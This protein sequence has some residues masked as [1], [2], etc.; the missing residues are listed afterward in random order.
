M[1]AVASIPKPADA[2]LLAD[3]ATGLT[4]TDWA[5]QYDPNNPNLAANHYRLYRVAYA[6]G[7]SAIPNFFA[8]GSAPDIVGP[9]NPAWDSLARHSNG[10]NIAFADGHVKHLA[11]SAITVPLYGIK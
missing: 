1:A 4:G 10:D 5:G 6:N 8:G 11:A 3:C 2:L 9:F 7:Y